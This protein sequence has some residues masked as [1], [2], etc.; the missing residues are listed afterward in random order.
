[1]ILVDLQCEDCKKVFEVLIREIDDR[2]KQVCPKCSSGN[3]TQK[4]G[5]PTIKFNGSGFYETDYK[6]KK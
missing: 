3:I 5:T 2:P 4:I 1:M 6:N